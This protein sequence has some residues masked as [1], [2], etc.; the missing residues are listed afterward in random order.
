MVAR[1][2]VTA[3]D[4]VPGT[5]TPLSATSTAIE[6]GESPIAGHEDLPEAE[7][8][9]EAVQLGIRTARGVPAGEVP[10]GVLQD[11]VGFIEPVEDRVV[12]TRRGRLVANEVAIRLT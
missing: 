1:P 7:R 4:G 8:R 9:R 3:T 2:T 6:S 10:D 5:S 11:L 12:L